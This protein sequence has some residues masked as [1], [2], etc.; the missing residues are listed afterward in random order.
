MSDKLKN[1]LKNTERPEIIQKA[2][3]F[4][5][6]TY[7]ERKRISQENYID[8]ALRVALMLKK[9]GMGAETIAA[10]ILHDIVDDLPPLAKKLQLDQIERK[11]GKEIR[12]LVE[13]ISELGKIHYPL[14]VRLKEKAKFTEEKFEN[15]R[16]MFLALAQDFRVI[17]IE[18]MSRLDNLKYLKYLS[19]EQQTLY[20][21]ET[22]KIFAPIA[23]R[24]GI[25]EIK[26]QLEDHAFSY[27]FPEKSN[28]LKNYIKKEYEERV[29]YLKSFSKRLEKILKGE[30]IKV[31]AINWRPKTYWSTYKKLLRKNMDIEKIHDLL[32]LRVIVNGVD[33]C[34]KTL[35]IIHK[36]YEPLG[37]EI[38]D[39]IA[40]PKPNGYRSLHTT[41]FSEDGQ[42][43]EVQ[44][45][46]PE[47][48]REAEF[49]ICAHWAYKEK[50]SLAGDREK[51]KFTQDIPEFWKSFKIDFYEDK[52]FTFTPKG[53][54]IIL[55]KD[56]TPIDFAYGVHSEIGNYC[57]IAKVNG[58]VVP[59]SQPLKNGDIIEITVNKKRKPSADWLKFVKTNLAT[60]QIKKALAKRGLLDRI[61]SIGRIPS[62]LKKKV[63]E[64]SEKIGGKPSMAKQTRP[65]KERVREL[66][67]DGQ[68]G[69]SYTPAKCCKPMIGDEVKA[70]L[71]KHRS[72]VLHKTSCKDF[73]KLAAKSPEKIVD[74]YWK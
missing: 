17:L 26:S 33:T 73:K 50:I 65:T 12:F 59:L 38:D 44:I 13:R 58:K 66:Y 16:Q 70:Y 57:E 56:S 20:S 6:T 18:L 30:R 4:A 61:S 19:Q 60:S 40:K 36:Y 29:K 15:L 7:G 34:Y 5:K 22:L 21:L 52:A 55:S 31:V 25:G 1:L 63:I 14:V 71:S 54:V 35:G 23:D 62:F 43:T 3:D 9:M 37:Q 48:H 51:L 64:I 74:A 27:L 10:G 24:L 28:W 11:I 49:G 67:I 45:K 42:I 72:A 68:K 41:V 39:Y 53:D 47:M 69:I 32:A 8:H 2:F 46:T